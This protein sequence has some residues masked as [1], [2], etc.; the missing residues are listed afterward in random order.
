MTPSLTPSEAWQPLPATQWDKA[1]IRHLLLRAGWSARREDI[2]RAATEGLPRT[3]DRLFPTEAQRLEQP[4]LVARFAE[5]AAARQREI[6]QMPAGEEKQRANR[7]QQQ[8]SRVALE[9][10]AMKWLQFAARPD[11]A[12]A[13]KWTLF[14]SD[15]YVV[16]AEKVRNAAVLFEHFDILSR[17]GFE[18]APT[19]TKAISRS[20]A[21]VVYLDLNQSQR[22]APNENFARELFELF[23][24]GEG[25]YTEADIKE[26]ARA[27][28]GYRAQAQQGTG[29]RFT[30]QQHDPTAKTIFGETGEFMGDD[31]I[32]LAY[33]QPAAARFLPREM[34]RFYLSDQPLPAE[35]VGALGEAWKGNGFNLRQLAHRF[36]GSRLFYAPEFRGNFIK[37]PVQF[38]L[39]VVQ[40]FDVDVAPLPRFT[41]TP[42][43]QMG[44]Q[45]FQPPNVRGWVGG[46]TWINSA[47]LAAR[48]QFV[49]TLFAPLNE[50]SLNADEQF[51]LAAARS[52]GLRDIT[53]PDTA[54]QPFVGTGA[55]DS[56]ARLISSLLGPVR[57]P[58]LHEN[59]SAFIASSAAN[60]A[61][62]LRRVRRAAVTLLQSPEYQLC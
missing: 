61:Q 6:N 26:A 50:G 19:L 30:P 40:D 34:A 16:S 58:G 32:D 54:L 29:F 36:F 31:V 62:H 35:H 15:V 57:D 13:A 56:A 60:D 22:R 25:N 48:R 27:F 5:Q 4:K 17:L 52:N 51:E 10:L 20:P 39:G 43:R 11:A 53:V 44:Q 45:L 23:V 47:T 46:R 2:D 55:K 9:E 21:M 28:T 14:L 49:E 38:Y 12:A 59:L 8:R 24:L 3:L 1:A 37:S 33:K 7:E 41:L 18:S 42:L